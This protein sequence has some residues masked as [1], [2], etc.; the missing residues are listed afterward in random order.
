MS[1]CLPWWRRH[2]VFDVG[3]V[4]LV[5]AP[6]VGLDNLVERVPAALRPRAEQ[7]FRDFEAKAPIIGKRYVLVF[8]RSGFRWCWSRQFCNVLAKN[9]FSDSPLSLLASREPLTVVPDRKIVPQR[10]RGS[11]DPF[12]NARLDLMNLLLEIGHDGDR[13]GW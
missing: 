7:L 5:A 1:C 10:K 6:G 9:P 13:P 11:E 4:A 12:E 2:S 8:A 3:A